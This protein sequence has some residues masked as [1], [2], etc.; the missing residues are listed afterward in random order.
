MQCLKSPPEGI[1]KHSWNMEPP[2]TD[3]RGHCASSP[4]ALENVLGAS[5]HQCHLFQ[6]VYRP[7]SLLPPVDLI[8]MA[9]P[10]RSSSPPFTHSGTEHSWHTRLCGQEPRTPVRMPSF[11]VGPRCACSVTL[12]RLFNVASGIS[13]I[14]WE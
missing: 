4:A 2:A 3:W 7:P 9:P 10:P 14:K 6:R 8:G 1:S 13:P 5:G 11:C 12:D